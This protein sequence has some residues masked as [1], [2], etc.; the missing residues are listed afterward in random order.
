MSRHATPPCPD[1]AVE[2]EEQ[3]V[4][5]GV[6]GGQVAV[7][8]GTVHG[9]LGPNGVSRASSAMRSERAVDSRTTGLA[10]FAGLDRGRF[11]SLPV[12]CQVLAAAEFGETSGGEVLD[13]LQGLVVVGFGM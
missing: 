11:S 2:A 9:L 8:P 12:H 5:A 7:A 10:G 6:L 4:E 13:P 1:L 3:L